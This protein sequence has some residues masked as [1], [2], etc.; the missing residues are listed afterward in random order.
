MLILVEWD[1]T[2]QTH[3]SHYPQFLGRKQKKYLYIVRNIVDRCGSNP[4]NRNISILQGTIRLFSYLTC[5][6]GAG[7][8]LPNLYLCLHL[9]YLLQTVSHAAIAG[10]LTNVR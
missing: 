6:P 9:S 4:Y 2:N 1:G 3:L 5:D 10:H 7:S 8:A